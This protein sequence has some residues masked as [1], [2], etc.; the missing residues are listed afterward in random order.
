MIKRV[1]I[2][3]FK[4]IKSL[5]IELA[6]LTIFIGPNGAGKSSILEAI[7]LM[8]QASTRETN[9]IDARKGELIN[10]EDVDALFYKRDT[11]DWLEL[12][13][14][15]EL[16]NNEISE[17]KKAILS[18]AESAIAD[19][20]KAFL[21]ELREKKIQKIKYINGIK[22]RTD[23]YKHF[24]YID[25]IRFGYCVE[26][27]GRK[28]FPEYFEWSTGFNTFLDYRWEIITPVIPRI[29]SIFF[30]KISEITKKKI[31][32]VYYLSPGRGNISW[33]CE[34]EDREP[35]RYVG[36]NGE[37]TIGNFSCTYEARK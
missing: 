37:H 33:Y 14:E 9:L 16:K 3:N 6:P 26:E 21:Y 11:T 10:I 30:E 32:N 13:I 4:S 12:G 31:A 24:Y 25:D 36:R 35:P 17:I 7:A 22:G 29:R 15:V 2:K 28:S 20:I 23:Y 18:D 27:E 19:E 1:I 8:S 34:I 5:D